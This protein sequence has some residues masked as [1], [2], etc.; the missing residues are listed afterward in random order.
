MAWTGTNVRRSCCKYFYGHL[1][2]YVLIY[3]RFKDILATR[4]TERQVIILENRE[5]ESI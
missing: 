1:F 2:F 5:V 4:N 3:G